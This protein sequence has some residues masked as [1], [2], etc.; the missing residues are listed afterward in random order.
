V[1][2]SQDNSNPSVSTSSPL[3][4]LHVTSGAAF[5]T[6]TGTF[7]S[8]TYPTFN[9]GSRNWYTYTAVTNNGCASGTYG[10]TAI[11]PSTTAY[12]Y[13]ATTATNPVGSLLPSCPTPAQMN[14]SS[15]TILVTSVAPGGALNQYGYTAN[16]V[17]GTF[18]GFFPESGPLSG[19][20]SGLFSGQTSGA[21]GSV[22]GSGLVLPAS[23][24]NTTLT[25][26]GFLSG[27]GSAT[28]TFINLGGTTG[29]NVQVTIN[30][31]VVNYNVRKNT[32]NNQ[33][34][35]ACN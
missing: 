25:S 1:Y 8:S 11:A 6:D 16:L 22:S 31:S 28:S 24:G 13:T 10:S 19:S 27:S 15:G 26:P 20:G 34:E 12:F 35:L 18:Y 33:I 2:A 32:S 30:G 7:W 3:K 9:A 5:P 21:V 23:G 4:V 29:S 17:N 14:G